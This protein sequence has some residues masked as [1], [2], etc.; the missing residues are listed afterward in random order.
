MGGF[1]SGRRSGSKR[2]TVEDYRSIDVDKLRKAGW[3]RPYKSGT[4][5][6][7]RDGET[8]ASIT[9]RTEADSV[10]LSYRM[11]I[12]GQWQDIEERVRIER[13]PCRLGGERPYFICP[14]VA[15]GTPCRK[16]VCRLY[17]AGRYFLCRHC[18]RLPYASQSED[19]Q[20]RRLR[21]ASKLWRR[22]GDDPYRK[23]KG[24][25]RG[26]YERLREQAV[27]A[28]SLAN[29]G[30]EGVAERFMARFDKKLERLKK[31]KCFS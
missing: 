17:R 15:N 7:S 24:M 28:E 6:W 9:I 14:G 19:A 29:E 3:L 8:T 31:K 2:A 10:H 18:Y 23:P 12:G 11:R 21:R 27:A 1:G 20:G 22:L 4:W 16:R 5:H 13:L 26:T 30:F 25:W